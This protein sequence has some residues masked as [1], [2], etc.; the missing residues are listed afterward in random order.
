MTTRLTWRYE[1]LIGEIDGDTWG[2][3]V[4]L[5]FGGLAGAAYDD[6]HFPQA[7]NSGLEPVHRQMVSAWIDVFAIWR[8][9]RA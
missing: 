7:M 2:W 1:D 8:A 9:T 4:A 5:P 3:G 6:A